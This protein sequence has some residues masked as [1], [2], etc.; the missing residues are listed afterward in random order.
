MSKWP[1]TRRSFSRFLALLCRF[2]GFVLLGSTAGCEVS[3]EWCAVK[4]STLVKPTTPRTPCDPARDIIWHNKT[5]QRTYK[6]C[7]A[8][9]MTVIFTPRF[10]IVGKCTVHVASVIFPRTPQNLEGYWPSMIIKM[11]ACTCYGKNWKPHRCQ[12]HVHGVWGAA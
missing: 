4:P 2:H 5:L 10:H 11:T 6:H 8:I 9:H 12:L 7:L 1:A 3:E